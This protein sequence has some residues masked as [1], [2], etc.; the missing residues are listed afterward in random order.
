MENKHTLEEMKK[1]HKLIK[2]FT[3]T[4]TP[5]HH[6]YTMKT[7]YVNVGTNEIR[8]KDI[9]EKVKEIFTGGKGYGLWHLW[10]AINENTKWNSPE[11]EIVI[12]TGPL[13]GIT[14]YP[15]TGKS[16]VVSLS[17][18]T[19]SIMDC[20]VGGYFGPYLKFNGFDVMEIQG[21]AKKDVII[22][23]DGIN[24][25]ITI[26]EAPLEVID[27]HILAEELVKMY[28]LTEKDRV[29][30][31]TISAGTGAEN[32]L[33][34]CLN[35]SLWDKKRNGTRL[36][37]AGRGG[38]GTVFRQKHIKAIVIRTKDV[39]GNKNDVADLDTVRKV[40][41][42]LHKEIHDYDE[43][44]CQ[45]RTTGTAHLVEIMDDYDLLPT[46]NAKFGGHKDA[47]KLASW[48]WKE[49]FTQQYPDGC[50]FGCTMACAHAVDNFQLKTGPYKGHKV[51]VDGPEYETAAAC[52]SNLGVFDP[53]AVIEMNFYCD[54]Y[55]I[56]T[57]SYGA[58][59]SFAMECFENKIITLKE[60]GGVD[61]TW[62]NASGVLELTHQMARGEGFGK[63]CGL[64]VRRMKEYFVKHYKADPKFL[65][66]IGLENKGLEYS[67]Y[68]SRESL[69]QQGGYALTN[70]G[71][72]HDEAWLI[73]MDMVNKQLPTFEAKA[74][75]LYYFPIFRTWF[76]LHGLCKLPWNDIEPADNA[77]HKE[78][79]KVPEHVQNYCDIVTAVTGKQ[80]TKEAL[81]LQ[82]ERVYNY[83]R[84]FNFRMGYGE[85]K[86]DQP[87]YRSIGPVTKEEYESR[88]DR[89]D[90]QMKE[91]I[92]VDPKGKST[93]E[94][95]KITREYREKQ[96]QTLCDVV[97]KRRGWTKN[98]LPTLE[99]AK[100]LGI[101]FPE[102]IAVIKK[103]M[104]LND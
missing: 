68:V 76:G 77:K 39:K 16:L 53:E 97:Y 74:E 14:Q 19:N 26:E 84:I 58:I 6:G 18:L 7:L 72:Q 61:L 70:K 28:S 24:S 29:F 51:I 27:S 78:P 41:I 43:K 20:N 56:D 67:M 73:F 87:P 63:I 52:G 42:K 12:G 86:H 17:P 45:M 98:A 35:F 82:S 8:V 55:G 21:I 11:N 85:R 15:G 93:E 3:Y 96:Y 34:G 100:R 65:Q 48:V 22:F 31:S 23:I 30:T 57:I 46:H 60:T 75:A 88:A 9:P 66:D 89:Y 90:K 1:A 79:Q 13:C 94:K 69:A 59:F 104:E 44:Q 50:W 49:K 83:Q 80:L 71:P 64:G 54:T 102:V 62:G 40:G 99:N 33:I 81:F 101:D 92:K 47:K 37:Q 5:L 32:S 91:I 103:H 36:K 25:K 2:E 38:L 4:S 95:M 10:Q